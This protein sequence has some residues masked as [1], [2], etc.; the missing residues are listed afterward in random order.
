MRRSKSSLLAAAGAVAGLGIIGVF[1]AQQGWFAHTAGDGA[2]MPAIDPDDIAG[3]VRGPQGPE[4]G[5][6]VIAETKDL[7]TK[8]ARIVATDDQGRFLVPDL[9][10]GSYDVWVR[11]YGLV[12]S[13]KIQAQPGSHVDLTAVAAPDAK[14][15]AQYY[16]ALYWYA[17]LKVP[18][19]GDFPGTGPAGNGIPEALQTQAQWVRTLKTEGCYSCHQLGN[20]ATRELLPELGQFDSSIDAWTRRIQSGQASGNMVNNIGRLD[21]QRALALFAD[22]TD[23]IKAGEIPASAP[24]RPQG[25]ERN[26][27][28]T[29]WDWGNE[30]AYLHDEIATDRRS[31]TVNANGLI[32]G[33]PEL[34][35]DYLPVLDPV[36]HQ[37]TL[38]KVPVLD[39]ETP[40]T[41]D[42]P[43]YAPS[44]Y[45]GEEAIWD[46]HTVVHNPMYDEKGRVWV[47]A[48]VRPPDANPAFCRAGSEHPSA[49]L[50]PL[51]RSGRQSAMYDPKTG[52]FKLLNLCFGTHHLQF[53]GDGRLYFSGGGQVLGWVD[54]KLFDAT[55]DAA[56]AQGWTAFVLDTN[57]NGKRDADYVEPGQPLD[58]ARDTRLAVGYYG[59][60]PSPLDGS[61]WGSV[62][63]FPGSIV[64]VVMGDAPPA[65]ALAETFEIPY[66][67]TYAHS[68]RGM[69]IDTKGVVWLPLQSGH[70][71]S[72]DRS[73][74]RGPMNGPKATGKHCPEGWTM[75]QLPGPQM[76]NVQTSGTAEAP[77]YTWVDQHNT[78]GLGEDI[79]LITANAGDAL[80]ALKDGK[81]ITLRVPYPMG[82][83]AKGLDGRI[84]DANAGW[85]GRGLWSTYGN[86][87]PFHI[88][89][90][91]GTLPKVV[92][93]QLRPDPLAH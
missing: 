45:W 20:K 7:P 1:A 92:K 48:R 68:P 58:P 70:L 79:P 87:T 31:P 82:F 11:G 26:I 69:D 90:G 78:F 51:E 54:P 15:A 8:F 81:F 80:I 91:K 4:A 93:F 59:L 36:R 23:R 34:S 74:C 71:A 46:S 67:T 83:F 41:H 77:Y 24:E 30:K 61:I 17:M 3:V 5:V 53:A 29:L 65:T 76:Q 84:D 10:G 42:D 35:S 33:S 49:K 89:G 62:Q 38:L 14:S 25:V 27:V 57:G 44:P 2:A 47:T 39:P 22:W 19:A 63:G 86:R 9:P 72:F 43:L 40:T 60:A 16:P 75:H 28:V 88:E 21:T 50:F 56:M 66:E 12:D 55:G 13:S 64:R 73:K 37:A 6:W 85:K 18:P 32:V 52:E